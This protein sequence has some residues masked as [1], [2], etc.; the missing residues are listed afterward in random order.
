[1]FFS[2]PISRVAK[3]SAF[4]ALVLSSFNLQIAQAETPAE[5]ISTSPVNYVDP[6]IGTGGLVHMYPGATVPFGMVQ[7]SP[8]T[9]ERG[10]AGTSGYHYKE[11]TIWGFSQTHLS[12]TGIGGLG[13]VL[14]MP[15]VGEVA[16][17][18]GTPGKGY[19][20]HFSHDKEEA[21]PGY[22]CVYLDNPG[23]SAELTAT[24]RCGHHRYTFPAADDAH[25]VIDLAHG[26]ANRP[27][28]ATLKVE[29]DTTLSGSRLVRDWGGQR[30]VYFVLQF[31]KPFKSIGIES[32]GKRLE[33]GARE[34][35]GVKVKTF[36]SYST[37]AGEEIE[38]KIGISGT[39]IDGARKNLNAE[40]PHWGFDQTHA[41]AREAWAKTLGTVEAK[42]ADPKQRTIFYTN[43]YQCFLGPVIFNDVDGAYR[44]LDRK[45]HFAPGFQNYTT[46]S[47]WDTFRAQAPLLTL[48]Q[49]KRV[50]DMMSSML[51]HYRDFGRN[52]MPV[53][54]LWGNETW[55]MIGYHSA[56]LVADAYLKGFRGFDA[57]ALYQALKDTA[58][59]DRNGL[60][61]YRKNGY[62]FSTTGRGMK[63]SVSRTLE[64][65]Y[66]DYCIA[67]L[68]QALGHK[69]DAQLFFKRAGNYRHLFD[70]TS[71]FMRGRR[72]DSSW[73]VPFT[74]KQLVWADYTEAN[75]WHYNWTVMQDVPDLINILGGDK[76]FTRK[77]DQMFSESS[78][79]PNAQEDIS[80]LVGQYAHGNEPDQHAPYFY[81]YAGVPSKTQA[82]VRQLMTE[83]YS[84]QPD[85]QCGNNDVGQ[86]SAWYIFSALGFYPVNPAGGD[87]VIGSP[88][89]EKAT[90]HLDSPQYGRRSFTVV[91]DNNSSQN[92]YIRSAQL[93]GKN[94]RRSWLS[95]DEL[96]R[97]GELRLKLDSKPNSKW[98][99]AVQD[100]P[101]SGM[102][103]GYQHVALP[104][105]YSKV[106][107]A[108][109]LPIRIAGGEPTGE[110]LFDPSITEG[111]TSNANVRID[112]GAPG[113]G[114]AALYQGERY[115]SD[116]SF[117]YSVPQGQHY[118]VVLHFAEIFDDKVGE[119]LQNVQINGKEV[120]TDF[121][122]LASAGGV[123]K[124]VVREFTD[125]AP[126]AE[127]KIVVRVSAAPGSIDRNAKISGFEILAQ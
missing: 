91:A 88:L 77:L 41:A 56:P 55:C 124:A 78:E 36:A 116:F 98:G 103:D 85:G 120:L 84:D 83:L 46:F 87:L 100:R 1:M 71:G 86:M 9:P 38:V 34:A 106:P 35:N 13:D 108:F 92:V 111:A 12:G 104:E 115:G 23:V 122:I 97:G 95:H 80:G 29:N 22:Y 25:I 72:T 123:N 50:P 17:E 19:S 52:S 74:P 30:E 69:E 110:F 61:E 15:M 44:G 45:N 117:S 14:V 21:S 58:M 60:D 114:P 7:I 64:Y 3:N 82:R 126:N 68:A 65:A 76:A 47:L 59:Q 2:A 70:S 5:A 16:L 26:I 75:A 54:P 112:T 48:L 4:V 42:I 118:R 40:I 11:N 93:N 107:L 96:I 79:V 24:T 102:P 125:I 6:M 73:R 113:A 90:I 49:P 119:R 109:S 8:D 89:V 10:W 32:D 121:D 57:E 31:S 99:S 27:L 33:A 105:P 28:A 63:Q 53:W 94:L 66:D 127:G 101:R 62:I 20:S 43:L 81:N 39:S 37:V 51:A 18:P 67:Q